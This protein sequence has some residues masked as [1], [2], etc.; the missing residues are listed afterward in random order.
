MLSKGGPKLVNRYSRRGP[1]PDDALATMAMTVTADG[2]LDEL[3]FGP[4]GGAHPFPLYRA[5]HGLG[6]LHRYSRDGCWYLTGYEVCRDM[7]RDPRLGHDEQGLS[8]RRPGM[9]ADELT[10]PR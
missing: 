5:L 3:F 1:G 2:V 9:T 7:L 8:L 6:E 4:D 10:F